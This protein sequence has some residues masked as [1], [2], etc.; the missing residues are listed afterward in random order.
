M[1]AKDVMEKTLEGYTE[2]LLRNKKNNIIFR[3]LKM[4]RNIW[5]I[6][7]RMVRLQ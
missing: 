1:S 2:V 3:S 5:K 4:G 6:L 7:S